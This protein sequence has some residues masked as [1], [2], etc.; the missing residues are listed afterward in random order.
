MPRIKD[1]DIVL[2]RERARIDEV[3]RDVV[4]QA[5]PVALP[6]GLCPIADRAASVFPRD[7]S[8]ELL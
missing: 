4:A 8:E 3:V 2:V 5:R 6:Q 7:A 1:T